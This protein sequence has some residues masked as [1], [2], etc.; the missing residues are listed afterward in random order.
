MLTSERLVIK[1]HLRDYTVD[2][3][4]EFTS[5]LAQHGENSYFI[6]DQQVLDLYRGQLH[7]FC[8][9][10]R[11]IAVEATEA[12]KT[13]EYCQGLIARLVDLNIRRNSSLVALGGGVIQD[14]T[15]FV[16]SV[17]FRGLN[18][19]FYPTTLLAQA[20]SC[21]GSK[22][23]LNLGPFKNLLGTF[24]PPVQIIIDVNLLR[25]LPV[26]EIKSGIGEILH[27]YL[28]DGSERADKL[29]ERY[30]EVLSHPQELLGHVRASLEIKR[31]TVEIDEFDRKE[32]N[33]FNYGHTFGHAIETISHYGVT[34]GQ[35]VTIGMDLANYI[36]LE[37]GCLSQD[38]FQAMR[39]LLVKNMPP[40]K[41]ANSRLQDYLTA[42]SKD[43]KNVDCDLTCILTAGPGRMWKARLPLDD[44]L[45]RMIAAYFEC[46]PVT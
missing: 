25:S 13:M 2:F 29:M 26:T 24:Y 15:A 18:W 37:T 43:K 3:L 36:S 4:G 5:A 35:A 22:S 44:Q 7:P 42:L 23:S 8:P 21:V 6:I 32:R 17:L 28:V 9:T 39:R 31:K 30:E 33:L 12:N 34:H 41:L 45:K 27:F 46:Y 16:A 38:S 19:H 20:D 1:S 11:L 14:I 40:F 10:Q